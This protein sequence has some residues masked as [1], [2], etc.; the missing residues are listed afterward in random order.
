MPLAYS[1]QI[2]RV[3]D[4][5][6][7]PISIRGREQLEKIHIGDRLFHY[8]RQSLTINDEAMVELT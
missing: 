8:A 4:L 6:D 7:T 2:S 3:E 1:L 5:I